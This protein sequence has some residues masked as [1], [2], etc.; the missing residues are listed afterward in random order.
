M[1]DKISSLIQ[2]IAPCG[3]QGS[4]LRS[5]VLEMEVEISKDLDTFL[6]EV[7]ET[8]LERD[9]S[10]KKLKNAAGLKIEIPKFKGYHSEMDIFTL[11]T[12]FKKLVEP[13]VQ[14]CLWADYLK[15]K[16]L[17]GPALNLVH[18]LDE[19]DEIWSKLVEV[20]GNTQLLLQNKLGSLGKFANLETCTDDEKISYS[21]ASVLNIMSELSKLAEEHDLCAELYYGDGLQRVMELVGN[22]RER[23]FIRKTAHLTLKNDEKWVKL[24]E[25]LRGE[26]REREAYVLNEKSKKSLKKP[27]KVN[28]SKK[29]DGDS[30]KSPKSFP[31]QPL[32]PPAPQGCKCLFCGSF[33]DHVIS[34]DSN[35]QPYINYFACKKFVDMT[36]RERNKFLF[37]KKWCA[38]CLTPGVKHGSSNVC[39]DRFLCTQQYFKYDG[40]QHRCQKHVLICHYHCAEPANKQVLEKYQK[41]VI[42]KGSFLDFS[43]KITIGFSESYDVDIPDSDHT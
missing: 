30:G 15:K 31:A 13:E 26:L 9:I 5:E 39:D 14:K 35:N 24:V 6:N 1:L 22:E 23:R 20:Y 28:D 21:L 33:R 3:E 12:E 43:K 36:C 25:F 37:S 40:T 34:I 32:P 38:K 2:Y 42:G 7:R 10:E 17:V 4:A 18:G 16:I 8:I 11:R 29:P 19:A 41:E 27:P